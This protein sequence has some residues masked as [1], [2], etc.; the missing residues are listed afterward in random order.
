MSDD[1]GDD[2]YLLSARARAKDGISALWYDGL[3][4]VHAAK[5]YYE[6][7]DGVGL[8]LEALVDLDQYEGNFTK[9]GDFDGDGDVDDVDFNNYLRANMNTTVTAYA[10]GDVD[11]DG[12]VT[13]F[14]FDRFKYEYYEGTAALSLG[15]PEPSTLLLILTALPAWIGCRRRKRIVAHE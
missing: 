5:P 8:L 14:D 1:T 13:L 3:L 4:R 15:I 9:F 6:A 7:V 11:G 12:L 2:S 10:G